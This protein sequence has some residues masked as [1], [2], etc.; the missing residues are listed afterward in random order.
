[1]GPQDLRSRPP[2]H[3]LLPTTSSYTSTYQDTLQPSTHPSSSSPSSKFR[4]E[5]LFSDL[6]GRFPVTVF[7]GS[8]YIMISQYKSYIHAELLPSRTE[9]SLGAA[10]TRTYQFFKDLGHQIQFQVL[11]NECPEFLVRFFKQE[12]V[13]VERVPPSQKR[14]PDVSK[15]I[16]LDPRGHLS[17]FPHQ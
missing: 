7:D 4:D 9:A 1:V 3:Q 14:D 10:F 12:Q 6:A 16:P 13:I 15:S 2:P 17:Q 8:Q 5:A 11:D